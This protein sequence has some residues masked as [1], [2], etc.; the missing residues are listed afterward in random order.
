MATLAILGMCNA[1]SS[2]QRNENVDVA[3]ISA[4]FA[5]LVIDGIGTRPAASWRRR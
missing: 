3:Q 2:W 5:R 4:E 1:V